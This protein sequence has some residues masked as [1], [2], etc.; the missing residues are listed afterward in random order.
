MK[1][2]H[3]K[4]GDSD[5]HRIMAQKKKSA[6]AKTKTKARRSG[7]KAARPNRSGKKQSAE[8]QTA[9]GDS[10]VWRA[11]KTVVSLSIWAAVAGIVVLV[12]FA[13][14]L[15]EIADIDKA[16]DRKAGFAVV[17]SDGGV[18][19]R[20]G[21]VYGEA[22]RLSDLPAHMPA[23]LIAIEDR[24]FRD[25]PGVDP[26]GLARAA[27]TNLTAGRVRQGGSTLTQQLAKNLFLTPDRTL[28]RKIQEVLLALWLESTLTK[29][30]ILEI[31]LNRVYLGG[32][33][34]GVDAAARLYFGIP[35]SRL[36]LF[37][38]AVLAG[39]PKAPSRY[40][41][42]ADPK[43]AAKRAAIVLNAMAATGTI[44]QAQ[45]D[46]AKQS[47]ARPKSTR[48]GKR[49]GRYFADWAIGRAADI[50]GGK[51]R[52][53]IIETTLNPA[54]QT[55]AERTIA[56]HLPKIEAAGATQTA[57]VAMR[58]DGTVLAMVGGRDWLK[59]PFNRAVHARRQPGSTFK[60]FA[61]L[62]GLEAGLNPD[63]PIDPRKGVIGDWTPR[64][65]GKTPDKPIAMRKALARS[66]NSAA[67]VVGETAGRSNVV[68]A[69]RRLGLSTDLSTDRSLTLGV[70]DVTLL[71]MTGAY[72]AIANGG[73]IALPHTI[74]RIADRANGTLYVRPKNDPER[75]V[76]KKIG[77]QMEAM[78]QGVIDHGTG[79]NAQI[80]RSAAGKSGTSQ[81]YRDAWFIGYTPALVVGVWIGN[82][83]A[84]P[85]D[86]ISGGG[87]P[88]RLWKDFMLEAVKL[89]PDQQSAYRTAVFE[90]TVRTSLSE[91][92]SA[93]KGR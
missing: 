45:A 89:V 52:D 39:L 18:I 73:K 76:S 14:D 80:G 81:D 4:S 93:D 78:L 46:A 41:P 12:F 2:P 91:I 32:G 87:H 24:R 54:L 60:L 77:A 21:A 62:A 75:V 53:L 86:N 11:T 61:Y 30:Q 44:T 90:T 83:D 49:F 70:H 6:A 56:T 20:T 37:Q 13:W 28:K 35:A 34:Y 51:D 33:A 50:A 26:V 43:Q 8:P 15:P 19:A 25:H 58:P 85:T 65:F 67:V 27:W 16:S 82:D 1:L 9:R 7:N 57:L 84:S 74:T 40:N 79:R 63:S 36:S 5:K 47:V 69:A 72:A 17:D 42:L 92:T 55:L 22:V 38:S 71:E 23:A 10:V 31:Y 88:A 29:D 68:D 66:L 3:F 64:D 48:A 59:F